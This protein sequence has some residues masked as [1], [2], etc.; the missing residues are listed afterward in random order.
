MAVSHAR[1]SL[2]LSILGV[3]LVV[4]LVFGW[5]QATAAFPG[6][7]TATSTETPCANPRTKTTI[8][9]KEVV[10][11]VYN[12]STRKGLADRTMSKLEASGFKAGAVGNAPDGTDVDYIEVRASSI[13]DPGAALVAAQFNPKAKVVAAEDE[14]GPGVD[15]IMGKTSRRPAKGAP[16][17]LKLTTPVVTCL[18]KPKRS[19]AA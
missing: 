4:M 11:S 5:K 14:L 7:D 12:G 1:T 15:V 2:T 10:V 17:A 6:S 3:L 8:T 16:P 9:R 19:P 13:N 18:D